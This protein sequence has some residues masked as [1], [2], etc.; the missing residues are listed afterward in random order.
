MPG[1]LGFKELPARL[2]PLLPL[3]ANGKTNQEIAEALGYA[4]HTI[5]VYVSEIK[6]LVGARD[7]VDLALQAKEWIQAEN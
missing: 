7:R 6:D 2:Q 4:V 5:E 3:L 1:F